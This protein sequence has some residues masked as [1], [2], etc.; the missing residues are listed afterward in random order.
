[1]SPMAVYQLAHVLPEFNQHAGTDHR[2]AGLQLG[3]IKADKEIS[4]QNLTTMDSQ[5]AVSTIHVAS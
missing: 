5:A 1:M 2:A 4:S 3:P